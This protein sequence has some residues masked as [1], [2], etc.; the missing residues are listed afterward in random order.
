MK[1]IDFSC[2]HNVLIRNEDGTLQPMDEP[3]YKEE[4]ISEGTWKILS[5]GDYS[6][7]VEGDNEAMV[8]D[9]GYGCGNIRE[10]CQTLTDKPVNKIANTHDHFDHTANNCYFECAY[11]A[12]ETKPLAT[13]PFPSFAGI[14]FPRDY[15]IEI[16][17]EGY[18]FDLGN[19]T[20]EVFKIPDH[21]VGSLAFLDRREKILFSGDEIG[22][23]T[24][25]RLN[26]TVENWKK[27][28]EKLE[29]HREEFDRLCAGSGVM[30]A[31]I[32]EKDIM[33]MNYI[34]EG[35]EGV[36]FQ[37]PMEN[38]ENNTD[39]DGHIIWNR[40]KPRSI[41]KK[42]RFTDSEFIRVMDY[43]GSRM[44]YDIRKVR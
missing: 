18:V 36:R 20:L 8:I 35:H 27:Q 37:L 44:I 21:A 7:L 42:R 13:M 26:G 38:V 33:C 43:A 3:Y 30:E 34:L 10:F 6:Y 40:R 16:I 12:E 29:K 32:I 41:D 39:E 9:S 25:K 15:K 22:M 11:M 24:G 4:K 1:L 28:M 2:K 19:R 5:D 17:D 14:T 23:S 31:S